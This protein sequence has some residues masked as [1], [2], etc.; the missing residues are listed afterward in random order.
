MSV[1]RAQLRRIQAWHQPAALMGPAT[2]WQWLVVVPGL[3]G[4]NQ[5]QAPQTSPSCGMS[6]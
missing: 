3:G 4:L 5:M 1:L 6:I 2:R